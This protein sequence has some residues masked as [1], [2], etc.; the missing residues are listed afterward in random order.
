M[1]PPG[2][3]SA[4][5][6]VPPTSFG[7]TAD[8]FWLRLGLKSA[9]AETGETVV[10]LRIPASKRWPGLRSERRG[11]G[12]GPQRPPASVVRTSAAAKGAELPAET[13]GGG[14]SRG[15][16]RVE[17]RS[18][19]I[20]PVVVYGSLEAQANEAA[21]RDWLA[22]AAVGFF[23]SLSCMGV[24]LGFIMRSRLQQINA[25]IS[26]LLCAYFL[27][28]DGSSAGLGLPFAAQLAIHASALGC[29]H[30]FPRRALHVRVH[31]S[32]V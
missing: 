16:A 12:T 11:E 25:V 27:L 23:G 6:P 29:V 20:L 8:I 17:S 5:K 4:F 3:W 19:I 30:E 14:G 7:F 21:K 28:I 10:E 13:G 32:A 2:A 31:P 26:L 24:V 15:F 22:L 1:E 18:S 9:S